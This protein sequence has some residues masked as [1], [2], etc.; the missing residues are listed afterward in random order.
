MAR[1]GLVEVPRGTVIEL[2]NANVSGNIT[3]QHRGGNTALVVGTADATE[4]AISDFR[5]GIQYRPGEGEAGRT[6]ADI[7]PGTSYVRLWAYAQDGA[8]FTVYHA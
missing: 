2:T 1:A 6:L 7:F 8:Q 3:F 4:P 5:N